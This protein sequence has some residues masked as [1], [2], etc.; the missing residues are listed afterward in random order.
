MSQYIMI[1]IFIAEPPFKP[2]NLQLQC[3][4]CNDNNCTLTVSWNSSNEDCIAFYDVRV[5]RDN[6][7]DYSTSAS[8]VAK[9]NQIS[10][11][12]SVVLPQGSTYNATVIAE[13]ICGL[14]SKESTTTLSGLRSKE[15]TTT[16][17][18]MTHVKCG[19]TKSHD[20]N[21]IT[22]LGIMAM[23]ILLIGIPCPC[24]ISC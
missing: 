15:S 3:Q 1:K 2:Q 18:E 10:Y 13:N 20:N 22:L 23:A 8:F 17:S 9:S 7:A 24:K 19:G 16:L 14:R 4:C 12:Y 21:I 11:S 6:T 5:T